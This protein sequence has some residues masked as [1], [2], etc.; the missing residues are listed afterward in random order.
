MARPRRLACPVG[1]LDVGGVDLSGEVPERVAVGRRER[2]G[3]PPPRR[4]QVR[5]IA[6]G[7]AGLG[8]RHAAGRAGLPE[9]AAPALARRLASLRARARTLSTE[10]AAALAALWP[11][12][13]GAPSAG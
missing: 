3:G 5:S 7:A 13:E 6:S 8:L 1:H 12:Q 10:D 4:L 9:I 2:D 11:A